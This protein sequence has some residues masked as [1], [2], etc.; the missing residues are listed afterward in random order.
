MFFLLICIIYTLWPHLWSSGQSSW[1]QIRMSAF[2]SRRY[3]TF[4]EVV[5][6]ERGPLSLVSTE[7]LPG[8]KRS[9]SGL[10]IREYGLGIRRAHPLFADKRRSLGRFSS[11]ADSGHEDSNFCYAMYTNSELHDFYASISNIQ[12]TE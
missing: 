6:L 2:D 9:G 11:L 4:W 1:L 3:Q 5:G 10:D 7:E 12:M 8:S